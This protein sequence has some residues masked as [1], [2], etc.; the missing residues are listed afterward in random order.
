M[1]PAI[2]SVVSHFLN[3]RRIAS[4]PPRVHL[5]PRT[6][7][8]STW[9]KQSR[10]AIPSFVDDF[11]TSVQSLP[12]YHECILRFYSTWLK[13]S[14]DAIPSFVSHFL[15]LRT[16]ASL[17]SRVHLSPRTR[18]YSTSLKQ[19]RDAIPSFVSH[20]LNLRTIASLPLRVHLDPRT[21]FYSTWLKSKIR[22]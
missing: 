4:L 19:S 15:N 2:L 3:L 9:L 16:I 10:D 20:F 11:S 21:R 7:F 5:S 13:Q 17:P 1:L 12:C 6:R 22:R 18:F 14:R 8:Y